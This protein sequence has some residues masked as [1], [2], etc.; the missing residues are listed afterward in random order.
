LWQSSGVMRSH[1]LS[2]WTSTSVRQKST[3]LIGKDLA[4]MT[5][6]E[7]VIDGKITNGVEHW[8]T[9]IIKSSLVT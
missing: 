5:P 4:E 7:I 8:V 2:G 3:R 6:D 9:E 1:Y